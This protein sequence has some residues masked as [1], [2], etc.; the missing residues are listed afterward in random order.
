MLSRLLQ[1]Y[2]CWPLSATSAASQEEYQLALYHY[3]CLPARTRSINVKSCHHQR[4]TWS[5]LTCLYDLASG[6]LKKHRNCIP[7]HGVKPETF[8]HPSIYL[9]N[10]LFTSKLFIIHILS[11]LLYTS[12]LPN[13][14]SYTSYHPCTANI[15]LQET[16]VNQ[17]KIQTM[18]VQKGGRTPHEPSVC[19]WTWRQNIN[20]TQ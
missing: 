8:K 6:S 5:T 19:L 12:L 18:H 1:I 2:P 4:G 15:W 13:S 7:R 11:C 20:I 16:G 17:A 3:A 14:L 10:T 9:Q